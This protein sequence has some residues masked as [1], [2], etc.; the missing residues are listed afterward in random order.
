MYGRPP[1]DPAIILKMEII[2]YLYK[3]SERQAEVYINENIPAKFFVGL[4]ADQKAPDHSTLTVFHERLLT[5]GKLEVFKE[6]LDEIIQIALDSGVQF[7]AIQIID[8]VHSV[9]NGHT[10]KDKKRAEKDKPR[11]PDARWGAKHKRKVKT[12]DGKELEQTEYFFG[13]KAHVSLNAQSGLIT[14]LEVTLGDAYDGHHFCSLVNN[15]LKQKLP[16]DTYAA[17]KGYDDGENHFYL[18]QHGLHSAICLKR[19]RTEKKDDNK[20]VWQELIH[21][22]QYQRGLKERYKIEQKF[23]EAKRGHGFDHCR[24][25]GIFHYA[26]QSFFT[27][28]VLNLKRMV[29]VLTGVGFKTQKVSH[30]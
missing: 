27:A 10:A 12:E 11:D 23:G 21:T 26:L 13:Y 30:A 1:F 3:L 22:P 28:M 19:T 24:Y 25:L 18:E 5:R 16:V 9:A 29:K 6:M 14:S 17:D 2:A 20:K 8:S 7:G 15:D 4:A